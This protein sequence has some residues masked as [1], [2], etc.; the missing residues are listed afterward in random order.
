MPSRNSRQSEN[1]IEKLHDTQHIRTI[2]YQYCGR[3][4]LRY[5]NG[6]RCPSCEAEENQR[7]MD[8]GP[9]LLP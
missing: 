1:E 8:R 4:N 7:G 5:P 2:T 9:A 3:H 6:E